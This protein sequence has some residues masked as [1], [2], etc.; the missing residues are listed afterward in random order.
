MVMLHNV[1]TQHAHNVL[2]T[3]SV[4]VHLTAHVID[5]H[6]QMPQRGS[7]GL[8]REQQMGSNSQSSWA[9]WNPGGF[10]TCKGED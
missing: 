4:S 9:D 6:G 2:S 3:P 8:L 1:F 7:R 5:S 10:F